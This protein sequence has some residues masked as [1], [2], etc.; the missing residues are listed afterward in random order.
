MHMLYCIL[1]I[2]FTLNDI[3]IFFLMHACVDYYVC[4][5]MN[6][7]EMCCWFNYYFW[8]RANLLSILW[9][10]FTRV[11]PSHLST[12]IGCQGRHSSQPPCVRT[13]HAPSLI[14]CSCHTLAT[15]RFILLSSVRNC[16]QGITIQP[17]LGTP[18]PN[19]L[20]SNLDFLPRR[21]PYMLA[22]PAP[23]TFW[24]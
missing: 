21:Y 16:G 12:I 22:G 10:I 8:F 6:I 17:T 7:S 24:C 3:C 18:T 13:T 5:C 20:R 1:A 19:I 11:F 9:C 14:H 2:L 4:V 15:S 23:S